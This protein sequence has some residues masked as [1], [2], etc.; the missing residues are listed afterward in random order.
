MDEWT[1]A[2]I[3]GVVQAATEFLPVSSSGHLVVSHR[4]LGEPGSP[5]AFD[6][7]L[8][9]GTL[10]AALLYFRVDWLRIGGAML[11]RSLSGTAGEGVR[12]SRRLGMLV[13]LA[14]VP[15]VLAGGLGGDFIERQLRAPPSVAVML[16]A[17]GFLLWAVDVWAERRVPGHL[18]A[19]SA[20]V[21]GLW[22]VLALVPGMSRSG[23]TIIGGRSVGLDR[24]EATR[25]SFMLAAPVIGGA[26]VLELPDAL[27]SDALAVGPLL[28]GMTVAFAVGL[29]V[30]RLLLRYVVTHGFGAFAVYRVGLGIVILAA[31]ATGWL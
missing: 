9:V 17:G 4:L 14:T 13:V 10:V 21:V 19:R 30:I 2:A 28:L 7:G 18:S 29:A 15:A 20:L 12:E 24:S 25:F 5:V 27:A 22:Q 3:L 31:V 16:I 23:A 26:A 6:I 8:H 11:G 1:R